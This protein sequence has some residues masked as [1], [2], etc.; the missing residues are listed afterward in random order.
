MK[1][2]VSTNL[3]QYSYEPERKGAKYTLNGSSYMN[4]GEFAETVYK[5][6]LG[7]KAE[8]DA[9]TAFDAGSDIPELNQSV[10]SSK[11]TL[12]NE[13]LGRD[14]QSSMATYFER[15]ASTSW[16]WVVVVDDTIT[17]YIMDENEFKEFMMSWANYNTESRIRFKV[18]SG[19][20]IAWLEERV[21]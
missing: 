5:Y 8:K 21:A 12:C 15:C 6:A 9:N 7:L 20:M 3:P 13:I 10:K 4:N 17:A 19:K 16:A 11:A 18:T 1:K 2:F 14:M